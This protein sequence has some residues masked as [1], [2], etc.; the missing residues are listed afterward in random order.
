MSTSAKLYEVGLYSNVA[1]LLRRVDTGVP[2][3]F[4]KIDINRSALD[5]SNCLHLSD[6]FAYSDPSQDSFLC[7]AYPRLKM[8][9][10]LYSSRDTEEENS[11]TSTQIDLG[12]IQTA[13]NATLHTVQWI[14]FV[15]QY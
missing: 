2:A 5:I 10:L 3:L 6:K 7:L 4:R 14:F 12:S 13:R 1:A 9:S 15:K 11:L 8:T